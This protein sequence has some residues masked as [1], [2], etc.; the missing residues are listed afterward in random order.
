MTSL[1]GVPAQLSAGFFQFRVRRAVRLPGVRPPCPA[2]AI[3]PGAD[4]RAH[5]SIVLEE[6]HIFLKMMN[7]DEGWMLEGA[8]RAGEAGELEVACAPLAEALRLAMEKGYL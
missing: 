2:Q 6:R 1:G 4:K 7:T 3:L 8:V 5:F